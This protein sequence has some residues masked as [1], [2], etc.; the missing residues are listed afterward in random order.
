[1][2]SP[3]WATK[4]SGVYLEKNDQKCVII[5]LESKIGI[6]CI[7][8]DLHRVKSMNNIQTAFLTQLRDTTVVGWVRRLKS[9]ELLKSHYPS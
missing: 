1:M 7:Y 5:N 3:F 4:P 8:I 6:E 2:C 9:R